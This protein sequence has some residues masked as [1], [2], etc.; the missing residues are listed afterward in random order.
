[1]TKSMELKKEILKLMDSMLA[2]GTK[3]PKFELPKP[4][5]DFYIAKELLTKGEFNLAVCGKV[6]NG[7]SSLINALIGKELLPVCNDVATSRVFKI[8]AAKEE[9]FYVVYANGNKKEIEHKDLALYGSQ[10]VIDKKGEVDV[11]ESIAYIQVLTPMDFIVPLL[12]RT[13]V[14]IVAYVKKFAIN[15]RK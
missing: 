4:E 5:K 11:S 6:K 14:L 3:Y 15:I 9:K 13:N 7:K 10:A 8:T 12:M 2:F 1:M